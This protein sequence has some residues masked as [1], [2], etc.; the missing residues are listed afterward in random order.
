MAVALSSRTARPTIASRYFASSPHRRQVPGGWGPYGTFHAREVGSPTTACG[1]AAIEWKVFYDQG[2]T[3][4]N[5]QACRDCIQ[6][7][8][9]PAKGAATA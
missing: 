1:M 6:V 8:Y 5:P 4:V 2:F 3:A 7:L 9:F